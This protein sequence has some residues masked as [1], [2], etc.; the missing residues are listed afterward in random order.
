MQTR[1]DAQELERGGIT[2]MDVAE[3]SKQLGG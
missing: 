3:A 1:D 2:S